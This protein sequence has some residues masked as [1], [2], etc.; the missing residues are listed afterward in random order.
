MEV[1]EEN[2][3]SFYVSIASSALFV[4]SEVLPY[5]T[6]IKSN[7]VI[8]FVID[9]LKSVLPKRENAFISQLEHLENAKK[10][11]HQIINSGAKFEEQKQYTENQRREVS[12][13]VEQSDS[14]V[15]AKRQQYP[16]QTGPANDLHLSVTIPQGSSCTITFKR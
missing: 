10:S 6:K 11:T 2:T 4:C 14:E 3:V 7:G 1:K 9:Y 13:N 8:Q 15:T 12:E 5:V 16:Y